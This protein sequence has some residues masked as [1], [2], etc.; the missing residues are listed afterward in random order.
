MIIS[1]SFGGILEADAKA[2]ERTPVQQKVGDYFESCVNTVEIDRAG[3]TPLLPELARLDGL[4]TRGAVIAA[5]APLQHNTS[6]DYFFRTYTG[7]DAVNSSKVIVELGAGGLGLP[8]R[9]YYMKTDAHSLQIQH[10]YVAYI[11][12]MLTLSGESPAQAKVDAGAIV[13][14]E[15][16]LAKASLTR[17]DRR[18]PHKTYHPMP[19]SQLQRQAPAVEWAAFFGLRGAP[20]LTSLNVSQPEFIRAVQAELTTEPLPVL[21]V[22]LKFHLLTASAPFLAKRFADPNFEFYSH[23]LRGVAQQPPRWKTCVRGGRPQPG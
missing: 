17:V 16:V 15:T 20:G 3:L 12:E 21:K 13:H 2:T 18:D 14:L 4:A 19:L 8:D 5:L 10:E 6:G 1:S 11:E 23:T 9:D 7:Q 22:Y